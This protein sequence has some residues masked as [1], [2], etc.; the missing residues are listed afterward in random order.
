MANHLRAEL[1]A[2][3][4][5]MALMHRGPVPGLVHHSE[6]G[7]QYTALSFGQRIEEAEEAEEARIFPAMCRVGS[8]L[9]NAMAEAFVASLKAEMEVQTGSRTFASR[10]DARMATLDYTEGFYNTS[11]RHSSIGNVSPANYEQ[12]IAGEVNVA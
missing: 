2:D 5:D 6:R 8:T 3:A 1:V 9:H 12:V 11:R 7:G 4:L 10:E